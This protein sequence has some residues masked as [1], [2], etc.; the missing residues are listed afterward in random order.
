MAKKPKLTVD[1]VVD[2]QWKL[3]GATLL[4]G[5]CRVRYEAAAARPKYPT[6]AWLQ[7]SD[8]LDACAR[9]ARAMA[10][11]RVGAER[12]GRQRV[13]A[14]LTTMSRDAWTRGGGGVG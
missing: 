10:A 1:E 2:R 12:L 14:A 9:R 4:P 3:V 11:E 6:K 7:L 8:R 13:A 5:T